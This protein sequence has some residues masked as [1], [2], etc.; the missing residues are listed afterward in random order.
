MSGSTDVLLVG[1]G[2]ELTVATS[3]ALER[4][5]EL[6]QTATAPSASAADTQLTDS[7][8]D[9]IVAEYDLPGQNGIELLET[10][11]EKYPELPFI[12]F[13]SE[14]TETVASDAIS[15]GVTDYV[16]QNECTDPYETLAD[17]IVSGVE[18]SQRTVTPSSSSNKLERILQAVP[19]CVVQLDPEGKFIYANE[20]AEDI[21]GLEQAE[22][23][24]RTYNEPGWCIRDTNG[25]P[26]P[27]EEL[28]FRQVRDSGEPLY[29]Y[30]HSIRWPDGSEVVLSVSG[31][32]LF[33]EGGNVDSIVFSL[34]DITQQKRHERELQRYKQIVE[35]LD[36][37]ATIIAPSGTITYVSPAVSEVL[38]YEPRE[39]IGKNGFGYQPP[40]TAEEV[41]QG[42]KRALDN[43][44]EAQ[45]VRT[46]FRHADGSMKWVESTLRNKV[47]DD[48]IDGILV[49][50]RDITE[51]QEQKEQLQ[52]REQQLS[53]LHKATRELLS[54]ETPQEVAARASTAAVNVLDF[55]LNGIHYFNESVSGLAPAAVSDGSDELLDNVPVIDE[56]IAWEVFQEGE[57]RVYDDVR[58]ADEVYNPETPIQ[59]EIL[60]P[61][62]EEGVFI[63]SSTEEATFEES[64]IKLARILAANTEAALKRLRKEEQLRSREAELE[65]KNDRL[66]EFTSVVSHDLRNP[67]TVA[68]GRL[69]VVKDECESEHINAVM[70]AQDRMEA[71]ISDL[72]ALA[73]QGQ[74][75]DEMERINLADLARKCWA[76]AATDKATRRI[77]A[78]QTIRCDRSRLQ[79]LLENLMRN[80]IEHGEADLTVTVGILEGQDGFYIA[81]DGPGISKEEREQVFDAGYSTRDDGTGFGLSIVKQIVE[82]HGWDIRVTESAAGGARFEI[83]GVEKV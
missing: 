18:E 3:N 66:E 41:A 69:E 14:G 1:D 55:Q 44:D 7:N 78:E 79:Q 54:A 37:V 16:Q 34:N 67:L 38:G 2:P 59:S 35:N 74:T 12:L 65:E 49:S 73:R 81:D 62:A 4:E 8:F 53:Q 75:I 76:N 47:A 58:S 9:C 24:G 20:R 68:Q 6:F 46:K 45:T 83:T 43:P 10:V 23:T 17:S 19:G 5:N 31:V 13:P 30:H 50:S 22:V 82:A 72:L 28:P 11:R 64:D 26:I 63:I 36:D 57:M 56:G 40:E 61:L 48:V 29:D 42:I 39:L 71:L 33:D 52:R 77:D 80:A 25:D 15:A 70:R 21:L 60:V 32:P 51:R 27:D